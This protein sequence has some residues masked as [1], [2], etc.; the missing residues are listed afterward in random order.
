M[1]LREMGWDSDGR[2]NDAYDKNNYE[3][4][5][6]CQDNY[7]IETSSTFTTKTISTTTTTTTSITLTTI[8]TYR[9]Q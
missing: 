5:H 6:H 9:G 2:F 8:T 3:E 4:K 1:L 7:N